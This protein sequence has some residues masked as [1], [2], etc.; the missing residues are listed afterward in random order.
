MLN[1]C[2]MN[3]PSL[4]TGFRLWV[5]WI[6]YFNKAWLHVGN[7][8]TN[9][10]HMGT[11]RSIQHMLKHYVMKNQ[12]D[13]AGQ[14]WSRSVSPQWARKLFADKSHLFCLG[15]PDMLEADYR[16]A[17]YRLKHTAVLFYYHFFCWLQ[18]QNQELMPVSQRLAFT[19]L[20][21]RR[22]GNFWWFDAMCS[23]WTF[24]AWGVDHCWASLHWTQRLTAPNSVDWLYFVEPGLSHIATSTHCTR[25]HPG[26]SVDDD[27]VDDD[28]Y[29]VFLY[30]R[31]TG[32]QFNNQVNGL[33][34]LESIC[35][36]Y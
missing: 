10:C 25:W 17:A 21:L 6:L 35:T 26:C 11:V 5:C 8:P 9:W 29:D 36:L 30:A 2:W 24:T 28:S 19:C 13:T 7:H 14:S 27:P 12:L 16:R 23:K 31:Y 20:K 3:Q 33:T 15:R 22:N 18:F 1:C 4:V 34:C 32:L